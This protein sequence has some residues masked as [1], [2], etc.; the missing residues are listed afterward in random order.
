VY[1]RDIEHLLGIVLQLGFFLTPIIYSLTTIADKISSDLKKG[2]DAS[3]A[4]IFQ[5]IL[6]INPMT[7]VVNASQDVLAYH[8]PP[9]HWLGL[10]YA[11]ALS[12]VALAV[13]ILV[14]EKL[15][16]HFAEEL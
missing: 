13:G 15:Q 9:E 10:I 8:R 6:R 5:G 7:W 2:Q 11:A 1:F 12:L 4:E 14:F 3:K 16:S